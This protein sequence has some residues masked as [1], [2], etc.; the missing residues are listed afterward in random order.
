VY[1]R[2]RPNR[3]KLIIHSH[4]NDGKAVNLDI[5]MDEMKLRQVAEKGG[6]WSYACGVA[7]EILI[8]FKVGGIELDNYKTD[9]PIQKGLSSSAAFCVTVARAFNVVY[10]LKLTI[11]G[12]MDIAY[13][14][15]INTPS[16]CGRMDQ[17][18]AFGQS[19]VSM[20]FDG[21]S[22]ITRE[23]SFKDFL[24]LVIVDLR[25]HKDTKKILADLHKCYPIPQS[26]VAEGVHRL[27]GEINKKT[28]NAAISAL[29][30]KKD[31]KDEKDKRSVPEIIGSLMTQAQKN[32]DTFGCPASPEEL[33]APILHKVLQY[34]GIQDLIFGGKG[35]GSQG[36]GSA[37]F[38]AKSK[39]AQDKIIQILE[40]EL[41]V[42]CLPLTLQPKK[43]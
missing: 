15:E 14:G 6:F 2:V 11:R 36:D 21:N 29:E 39:E 12:E 25:G 4:L 32:F 13:R 16:R 18:C 3:N 31:E 19:V 10:D 28:L 7:L 8:H 41:N 33:N 37:Q 38:V 42:H 20:I 30:H 22:L 27:L 23:V 1:G 26:S 40:K 34:E 24:Y 35:V 9:L 17:C 5:E 43:L